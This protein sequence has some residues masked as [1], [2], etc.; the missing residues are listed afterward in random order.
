MLVRRITTAHL[1]VADLTTAHLHVA[2][3]D[4]REEGGDG[5]GCEGGRGRDERA[6]H[7][8]VAE[9]LHAENGV[10]L[11]LAGTGEKL[12]LGFAPK[13]IDV[14]AHGV[15]SAA[16]IILVIG[17]FDALQTLLGALYAYPGGWLTDRFGVSWQIVPRRMMAMLAADDRAARDRA[18]AA[19][20]TMI[21][22]DIAALER[23]F[24]GE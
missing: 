24:A 8:A 15:L 11:V 20:Q 17:I 3:L 13:Y 18:F 1:H 14:L 22:L 10:A 9:G 16:Q 21:K 12:W 19:M 6:G 4:C 2:D 23:A 7:D 5:N